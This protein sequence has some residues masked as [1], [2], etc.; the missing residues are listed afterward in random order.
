MEKDQPLFKK[1]SF[2]DLMQEIHSNQKKK[3][4]QINLL[5]AELKPLIRSI[6]DATVIVPLIKEY[7]E[8]SVKNDDAL[9]KLLAVVQR[10]LATNTKAAIAG[11]DSLL[12]TEEEK[13]QLLK[14]LDAI[15]DD[16]DVEEGID[17]DKEIDEAKQ[18]LKDQNVT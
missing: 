18:K 4:R 10:W 9:V 3:D 1:T 14:D 17:L 15:Q 11:G 12:I 6:S 7:L 8:V 16:I 2:A 5:I 13:E